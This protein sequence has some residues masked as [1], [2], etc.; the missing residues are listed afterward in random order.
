MIAGRYYTVQTK[1]QF[2]VKFTPTDK[3]EFLINV[4]HLFLEHA[5]KP[6]YLEKSHTSTC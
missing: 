5:R 3:L 6:E 1:K 4:T 2:T